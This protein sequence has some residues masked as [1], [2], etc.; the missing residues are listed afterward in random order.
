MLHND[1]LLFH[2]GPT[3]CDV[4]GLGPEPILGL[5]TPRNSGKACYFVTSVLILY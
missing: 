4:L 5:A 2:L 1:D 3:W